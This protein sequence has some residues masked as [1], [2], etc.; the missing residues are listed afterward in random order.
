MNQDFFKESS[1]L[2]TTNADIESSLQLPSLQIHGGA[3]SLDPRR[4]RFY[5]YKNKKRASSTR[6][7]RPRN[8]KSNIAFLIVST[9]MLPKIQ[10]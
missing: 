10:S 5:A 7:P 3:T 6:T 9:I 4:L 8:K 1:K 2:K